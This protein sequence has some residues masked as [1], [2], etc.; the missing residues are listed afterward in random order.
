MAYWLFRRMDVNAPLASFVWLTVNG[1]PQGL[2]TA[3]E[4]VG[5]S[6]LEREYEGKGT[7]YKPEIS[8]L[9]LDEKGMDDLR[10][11]Q[12]AARENAHGADL[13]Y[14]DDREESYPDIFDHAET[15]EGKNT[16]TRV[17]RSLKALGKPRS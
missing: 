5:D 10:E 13:I 2:Y 16:R 11:G 17:I 8:D 3:V 1:E 15:K 6:F 12:S 14:T 4:Y 9:G 7:L